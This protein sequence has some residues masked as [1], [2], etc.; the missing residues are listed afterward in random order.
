MKFLKTY[1]LKELKLEFKCILTQNL[2]DY[3]L[4]QYLSTFLYD[5]PLAKPKYT[6]PFRHFLPNCSLHET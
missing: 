4:E 3:D 2:G 1:M 6:E 5:T